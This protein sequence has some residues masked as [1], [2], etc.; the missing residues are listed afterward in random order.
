ME[1]KTSEEMYIMGRVGR[2]IVE[3]N[4]ESVIQELN[5][6]SAAELHDAYR[7]RLLSKLAEGHHATEVAAW[8]AKT[9]EDEWKHLGVWLDRI[10]RLGGR[11]FSRPSQGES[12][13]YVPYEDPPEDPTDLRKM[14][15]DSLK[16]ERAAI[17]F[18]H[19]LYMKTQH[20][21]PVTAALAQ[22]ALADEVADEDDLERFLKGT[23]APHTHEPAHEE[24]AHHESHHH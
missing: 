13:A 6:A 11:P 7:Y 12:L 19:E 21:D 16:G 20:S 10:M 15:E 1:R 2:E 23:H 8:F 3:I 18:Y 17:R 5:K 14:I 9:A 22:E 24:P 4:V